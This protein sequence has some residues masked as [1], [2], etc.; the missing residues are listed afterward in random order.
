[1]RRIVVTDS[2]ADIPEELVTD[3]DIKVLPVNVVLDGKACKDNQDISRDEFYASFDRF[4]EMTSGPVRYEDYGLEFHQLRSQYDE[5]LVI[6]CSRHLS[7]TYGV[8][9]RVIKEFRAEDNRRVELVDSGQCSMGLGMVVL[10]AAEA[11]AEGKSFDQA[12]F[13]VQK[14]KRR[15]RSYMAIPTLKYLKK[16][17]KINGMKALF[18]S[19]MGIKPVLEMKEGRMVIKSKLLGEQKNMIL[20]M[21]ESIKEEVANKPI[22]LSIIYAGNNRLVEN[23]KE[24]FESTFICRKTYIARFSPSISLNTGPE[25]YA[26]FF[27]VE[28]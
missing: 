26:V 13:L 10:A 14:L 15:M 5:I 6:H 1:M 22:T 11:F 3:L 25:S 8:A 4:K 28:S 7:G 27:I 9:E 16:N 2:T 18:G 19:A 17:R 23:L 20:A 24:V 21:M 12:L